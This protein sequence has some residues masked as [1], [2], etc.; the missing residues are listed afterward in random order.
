MNWIDV[1]KMLPQNTD[2]VLLC[3]SGYEITIG[4]RKENYWQISDF[5]SHVD[6]RVFNNAVRGHVT[7]WMP[8]PLLPNGERPNQ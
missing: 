6:A 2:D 5:G 8:L 3:I 7:H 1:D 4:Y